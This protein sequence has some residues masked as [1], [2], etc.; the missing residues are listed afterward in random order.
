MTHLGMVDEVGGSVGE[1]FGRGEQSCLAFWVVFDVF[2]LDLDVGDHLRRDL[3]ETSRRPDQ[4]RAVRLLSKLV[5]GLLE[6]V[7]GVA[8]V[9]LQTRHKNMTLLHI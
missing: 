4:S 3:R 6:E 8:L 2:S 7:E 9:G 5:I 1:M